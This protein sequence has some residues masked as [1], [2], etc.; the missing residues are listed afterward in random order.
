MMGETVTRNMYSK[1]IANKKRNYCILLDLFHHYKAWCTEPQ[2][3]NSKKAFYVHGSMHREST[4][5]TVQQDATVYS[6]IIFSADSSTCFV[7][8]P[9]PSSEAHSNCNWNVW[10][11][12][13]GLLHVSGRQEIRSD[14]CQMLQLQFELAPDDGWGYHPEHVELSAENIIKLY[15]VASCWTINDIQKRHS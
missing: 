13:G 14:Q 8:Y 2:I 5:I 6:Y 11:W 9:Y 1:A 12:L 7:W 4:S 3:L 10:H 15:I